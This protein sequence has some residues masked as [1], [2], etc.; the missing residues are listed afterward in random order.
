MSSWSPTKLYSSQLLKFKAKRIIFLKK[1]IYYEQ[2]DKSSTF[3]V[4]ALNDLQLSSNFFFCI[5]NNKGKLEYASGKI[6]EQFR[7]FYSN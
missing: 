4:R 7:A 5:K 1:G 6:A 3:L 2:G